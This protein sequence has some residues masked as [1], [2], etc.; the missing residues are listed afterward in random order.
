MPIHYVCVGC[1]EELFLTDDRS[2]QLCACTRCRLKFLAPAPNCAQIPPAR[3]G[4]VAPSRGLGPGAPPPLYPLDP[5]AAAPARAAARPPARPVDPPTE[6]APRGGGAG[7]AAR[8]APEEELFV[9]EDDEDE[10]EAEDAAADEA[11]EPAAGLFGEAEVEVGELFGARKARPN[12]APPPASAPSSPTPSPSPARRGSF[13]LVALEGLPDATEFAMDGGKVYLMGRDRDADIK[14]LS[15]SVSRRQARI[16]ATSE[17]PVLIDLGSANGTRVNG[18][19]VDRHPLRQGDLIK[20][21][22]VLLRFQL[23]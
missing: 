9:P 11:D 4:S 7:R 8:P 3:R 10:D 20:I 19:T 17:P 13:R 5:P 6:P 22:K 23:H 21:G 2:G 15:T 16:D 18:A 12:A 14:L 1:R